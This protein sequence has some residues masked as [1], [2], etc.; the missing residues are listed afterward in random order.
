MT[1]TPTGWVSTHRSS[2]HAPL[3][4]HPIGWVLTHQSSTLATVCLP[5][6]GWVLTHQ[7]PTLASLLRLRGRL[8]GKL[9]RG[10]IY[11][12]MR[13][14]GHGGSRPTLYGLR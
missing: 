7:S 2:T 11:A 9:L 8:A 1:S 10:S 3:S 12:L 6:I 14:R 5:S 13:D 4:P